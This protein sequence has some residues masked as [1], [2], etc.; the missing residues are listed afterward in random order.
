MQIVNKK[1][2]KPT[3]GDAKE[4]KAFAWLP[5]KIGDK[6]VWLESYTILYIYEKYTIA[7]KNLVYFKWTK[8]SSKCQ[9]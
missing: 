4:V 3:W 5:K 1:Y 9:K 6:I 8:I 2:V 7:I